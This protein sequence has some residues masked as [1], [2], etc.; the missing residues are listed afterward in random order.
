LNVLNYEKFRKTFYYF[1]TGFK[2]DQLAANFS[3]CGETY[4]Y[5]FYLQKEIFMIKLR[6]GNGEENTLNTTLFMQ[7]TADMLSICTDVV[8][9]LKY[10]SLYK[11]D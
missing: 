6:Y 3:N 10:F 8:E 9:N 4:P 5:W 1:N 7:N 11:M 2:G